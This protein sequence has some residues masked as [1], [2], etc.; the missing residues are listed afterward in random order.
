MKCGRS[1]VRGQGD[2]SQSRHEEREFM[3]QIGW[4]GRKEDNVGRSS[5]GEG[6]E[7]GEMSGSGRMAEDTQKETYLGFYVRKVKHNTTH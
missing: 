3:D 6:M 1:G 7:R 2:F 5:F 4:E